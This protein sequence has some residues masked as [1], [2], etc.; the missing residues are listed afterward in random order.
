MRYRNAS[1]K[2][3]QLLHKIAERKEDSG[4]GGKKVTI[5]DFANF[6]EEKILKS[7]YSKK[8]VL[9]VATKIDID[10]DGY[11]GD[12]DL[13][14]FLERYGY[15]EPKSSLRRSMRSS[16]VGQTADLFPKEPLSE[17]RLQHLLRE[18]HQ[19]MDKKRMSYSDFIRLL[20]PHENGTININDFNAGL[21]KLIKFSAPAKDGLF[22]YLDHLKIGIIDYASVLR[23]LKRSSMSSKKNV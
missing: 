5:E 15:L 4:D 6:V 19:V 14:T 21:D 3:I 11:I 20:D 17:E 12:H 1:I 22:A 16:S 23:L 7:K 8:S 9:N 18:L 10:N 13:Q 2:P